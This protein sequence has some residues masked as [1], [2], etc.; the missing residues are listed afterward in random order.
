MAPEKLRVKANESPESEP[1]SCQVPFLADQVSLFRSM[2][3]GYQAVGSVWLLWLTV[4]VFSS[5]PYPVLRPRA[6]KAAVERMWGLF[7]ILYLTIFLILVF[8]HPFY[9]K[10]RFL[11]SIFLME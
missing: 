6:L 5:G 1:V 4:F 7:F 9:L 10:M 2:S 3:C 11:K 8:C